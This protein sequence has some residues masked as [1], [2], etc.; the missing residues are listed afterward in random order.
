MQAYLLVYE[1]PPKLKELSKE[2]AEEIVEAI[3]S[4]PPQDVDRGWQFV[5]ENV[6]KV[7]RL[8]KE[9]MTL[10]AHAAREDGL[11]VIVKTAYAA[12]LPDGR[13]LLVV[14]KCVKRVEGVVFLDFQHA[15]VDTSRR[16]LYEH[17]LDAL[18]PW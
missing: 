9:R 15:V 7:R 1:A 2:E 16:N 3:M 10:V 6:E 12:W 17:I 14:E 8:V 11:G 13:A 4:R 18:G 5:W